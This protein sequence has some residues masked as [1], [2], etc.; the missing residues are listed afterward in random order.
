MQFQW[1]PFKILTKLL[2]Q[3]D[4]WVKYH[5]IRELKVY[6]KDNRGFF[7]KEEKL[8]K[9]IAKT[10]AKEEKTLTWGPVVLSNYYIADS[11]NKYTENTL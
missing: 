7:Q 6:I 5:K 1:R 8:R 11:F 10:D 9:F 4:Q 3:W 2:V